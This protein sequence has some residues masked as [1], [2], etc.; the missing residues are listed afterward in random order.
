M[1]PDKMM[2]VVF[3]L[4]F[5]AAVLC[6]DNFLIT[7]AEGKVELKQGAAWKAVG[8]GELL[9]DTGVVRIGAGAILELRLKNDTLT[10]YQSGTYT[11]KNFIQ[12]AKE[13]KTSRLFASVDTK[14]KNVSG[15]GHA[16]GKSDAAAGV[17]GDEEPKDSLSWSTDETPDPI[18]AGRRLLT[19]EKYK[20]AADYFQVLLKNEHDAAL[21]P[22]LNYYLSYAFDR[23]N[24]SARALKYAD[25]I[26][27][28]TEDP[29]Y[30]EMALFKGSLL[31][32]S[33]SFQKALEVF[34]PYLAA[35][36]KGDYTQDVL[37]LSA[38]C[39]KGS[40][41]AVRQKDFLRKA[42][43]LDPKSDAGQDAAAQL[44]DLK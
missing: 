29:Q 11:L 32:R 33:F 16:R 20:A 42:V 35:F 5:G 14:I 1:K 18:P 36:P 2:L 7:Y 25:K 6:A 44:K 19:E 15:L 41:D 10:V 43:E 38:Y 24:E 13:M 30:E 4:F 22:A 3:F 34:G 9:P 17:K 31:V 28:K 21:E 8:T 39:A 40:G 23:N 26:A 37:L 27:L 12:P